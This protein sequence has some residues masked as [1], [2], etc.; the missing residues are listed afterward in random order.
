MGCEA[1]GVAE[2][3]PEGSWRGDGHGGVKLGAHGQGGQED[4]EVVSLRDAAVAGDESGGF[5][6][7][8]GGGG[9]AWCDTHIVNNS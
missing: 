5:Q 4:I 3:V 7:V 2:A 8:F 9:E 6:R 1:Y